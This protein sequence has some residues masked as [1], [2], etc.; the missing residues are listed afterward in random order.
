MRDFSHPPFLFKSMAS[1]DEVYEVIHKINTGI[2]RECLACMEDNSNVIESLIR[3]Q[4]YSGMNGKERLLRPYYDNDPYFNEPGPWFHR[5]KS[6]KKWKN[7]ITPPIESEVLFLPPRPVEVPNLYITGKFH[8]SIQARLSGEVMEIKT[9]G[10][11]EGP[12]IEKKYGSEIF[13]LG[14]TAKKYFSERILRPWLEKFISNSGY[15]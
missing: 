13:E 4:L 6:Y 14:D 11:N 2:K 1:I 12:D 15:R 9:I 10:F 5:A 8:D 3:E 7:D